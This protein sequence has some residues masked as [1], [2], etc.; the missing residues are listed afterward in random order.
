MIPEVERRLDQDFRRYREREVLD[1]MGVQDVQELED[2]RE[3]IT[4]YIDELEDMIENDNNQEVRAYLVG[5]IE[6][7]Q[8]II[9]RLSDRMRQLVGNRGR[10]RGP[11]LMDGRGYGDYSDRSKIIWG[12]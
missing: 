1:E 7:L 4:D 2:K 3:E 5:I 6:E 12:L 10:L 11:P 9:T 8:T